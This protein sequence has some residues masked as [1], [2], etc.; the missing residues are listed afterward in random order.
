MLQPELSIVGRVY[1]WQLSM[2]MY[3]A[4]NMVMGYGGVV[5]IW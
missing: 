5:F 1:I 4:Y 2:V 3:K